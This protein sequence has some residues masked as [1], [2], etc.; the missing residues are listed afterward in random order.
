MTERG[1]TK[2]VVEQAALAWLEST[3]WQVRSGPEIAPGEPGS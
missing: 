1:L 2:S 3:G